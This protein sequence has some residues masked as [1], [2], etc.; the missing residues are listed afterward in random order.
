MIRLLADE[1]F[2]GDILRG[3]QRRVPAIDV[4]RV[5]DLSIRGADDEAVLEW[6]AAE[7][8]MVLTHDVSTLIDFAWKR[9]ASGR[10]H[11]GVAA[12]FAAGAGGRCRRGPHAARGV[13]RGRRV[14]GPH[15]LHPVLKRFL[16]ASALARSGY[17]SDPS[18]CRTAA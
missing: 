12:R 7:G 18:V 17:A 4:P 6:A 14:G 13:Q 3:L 16:V 1:N 10:R 15:S 2:N 11:S 8:R 9:V 5:Q